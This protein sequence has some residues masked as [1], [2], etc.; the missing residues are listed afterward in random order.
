M[1]MSDYAI[2]ATMALVTVLGLGYL[3]LTLLGLV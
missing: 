1:T 3:A 2:A